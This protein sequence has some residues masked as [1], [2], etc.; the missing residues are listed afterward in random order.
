M[1]K[2]IVIVGS[3]IAAISAIKAIR[4]ID[5]DSEIYLIGQEKFYPI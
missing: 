1:S 5:V 4:E 3:G 2:R